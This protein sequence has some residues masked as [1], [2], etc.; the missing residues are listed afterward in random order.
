MMRT[1]IVLFLSL[2]SCGR[3]PQPTS[4]GETNYG[5][6]SIQVDPAGQAAA[7]I[8]V[9]EAR[10]RQVA[11]D[12]EAPGQLT[13]NEDRTWSIG[14]VSSGKIMSIM[15]RVGDAVSKGQVL[16]RMHSHDVHDTKAQLRQ[17][18][19]EH[20]RAISQLELAKRNRERMQRL[21][22]L[23]AVAQVQADQADAEVRNAEAAVKRAEADVERETQHLT[24]VLE[25]PAEEETPHT[26]QPG[27]PDEAELVPI[28][29]SADGTVIERK[30]SA[31]A[32]VT[33]GETAFVVA[34]PESLW[35][36]ASFPE[37]ALPAL[38]VGQPVEIGVQAYPD[39]AFSGRIVRLG[40]TLDR[41]TRTLKVRI[42]VAARDRLKPEMYATVRL[43]R[44]EERVLTVPASAIQDIDG[45]QTV[46]V[47]SQAGRFEPRRVVA[48]I[49]TNEALV[50]VGLREGDRVATQGSYFLKGHLVQAREGQ[51][52]ESK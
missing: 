46:F 44:G 28:K 10:F 47:E 33:L 51:S 50:R 31:G 14:V 1:L 11:D 38:R 16:A 30:I 34:D 15:A 22:E 40:D 7:K 27:E 20:Q 25:V 5:E 2:A 37:R 36:I 12:L 23:K 24:E 26:H 8:E 35:L 3:G 41:E 6:P 39:R 43:V 32:V 9:A 45:K 52:S 18:R 49:R 42:A 4:A 29:S 17:A 21:L 48:E 19:T 13:W